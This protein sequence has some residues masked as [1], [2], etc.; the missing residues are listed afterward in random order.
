VAECQLVKTDRP[1]VF[2]ALDDSLDGI[3]AGEVITAKYTKTR[4]P[5]FHRKAMA[6]FR[7]IYDA[8]PEPDPI[9][10]RGREISL[11]AILT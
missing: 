3:S 9:K 1:R 6:L 2:V 8:M 7:Y 11:Y 4:N 10:F 5:L